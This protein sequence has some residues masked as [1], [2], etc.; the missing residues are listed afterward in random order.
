MLRVELAVDAKTL[1]DLPVERDAVVVRRAAEPV[2]G[3]NGLGSLRAGKRDVLI[4]EELV[5]E[6]SDQAGLEPKH[7]ASMV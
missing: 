6:A 2:T 1:R 5:R 3:K 4:S 7:R